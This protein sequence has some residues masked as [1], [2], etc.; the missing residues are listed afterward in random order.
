[1]SAA[2]DT[3]DHNI[4][5]SLELQYT[6]VVDVASWMR[7]KAQD[8]HHQVQ[9]PVVCY[10][11]ALSSA[12]AATFSSGTDEV[13]PSVSLAFISTLSDISITSPRPSLLTSPYCVSHKASAVPSPD[14]LSSRWYNVIRLFTT[15][16]RKCNSCRY[17]AVSA[18]AS[19]V[20]DELRC[21]ASVLVVEVRPYHSAPSRTSL[22]KG[23]G[24]D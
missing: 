16:S 15:G 10:R 21:P 11:S 13:T 18:Q 9:D 4:S 14:P 1:M 2:F 5:A 22:V 19:S 20:D 6:I 24:E 12:A 7:S 23:D 3:V 8:E 17:S